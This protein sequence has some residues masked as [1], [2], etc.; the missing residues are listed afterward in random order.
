[1]NIDNAAP[2]DPR[3][4]LQW[5]DFFWCFREELSAAFLRDD[6]YRVVLAESD[7]WLRIMS[8]PPDSRRLTTD[9]KF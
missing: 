5:R 4:I 1:V 9:D 2:V 8:K 3:D 7:E 6:N